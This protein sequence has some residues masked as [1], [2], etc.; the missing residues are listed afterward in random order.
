MISLI[1][2][3]AIAFASVSSIRLSATVVHDAIE[4]KWERAYADA[5]RT[6][7]E[8]HRYEEAKAYPAA[9][10]MKTSHP[11]LIRC[12]FMAKIRGKWRSVSSLFEYDAGQWAALF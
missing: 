10:C 9:R 8:I 3:S 2:Q 11:D 7:S 5:S 6:G 1:L 4:R 12:D